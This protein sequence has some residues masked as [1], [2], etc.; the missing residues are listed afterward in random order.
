M[1]TADM[2]GSTNVPARAKAPG[3]GLLVTNHL[4]LMYMLA[5]GPQDRGKN[6]RG[7]QGLKAVMR[8]VP[9]SPYDTGSQAEKKIFDRLR[10]AL[11]RAGRGRS[12]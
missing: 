4:N 1:A 6:P 10:R 7:A 12:C 11:C 3:S 9:S 2:F 5:S 8:M